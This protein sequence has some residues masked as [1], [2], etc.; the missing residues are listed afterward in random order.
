MKHNSKK[1]LI[2]ITL[3]CLISAIGENAFAHSGRT[4]SS[5]GHKDNKNKSGLGGYHYHCGGYP[6]H[7]HDNGVCPYSS[8]PSNYSPS[9]KSSTSTSASK[10]STEIVPTSS[11]VESTPNPIIKP[12]S[13][14][15]NKNITNMKV[16]ETNELTVT[17]T[18]ENTE[19]ISITWS[20]N[21][22]DIATVNSRGKVVALKAGTVNITATTSNGKTDMLTIPVEEVK[23]IKEENNTF[24]TA[25]QNNE[26]INTSI[27]N[28]EDSDSMGGVLGLG[29]IGGGSY[30]GYKK[31]KKSKK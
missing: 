9:S 24:I 18:P 2:I 23:Q 25:I 28:K 27:N 4:D 5:G 16:G 26:L 30:L 31:Y 11:S 7:L 6:D 3:L 17:I 21:D 20:S 8:S 15:I 1:F 22:E 12:T 19:N 10:S 29:L 13:V 14:K